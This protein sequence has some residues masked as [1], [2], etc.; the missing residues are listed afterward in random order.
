MFS[1]IA[2]MFQA[3]ISFISLKKQ[4]ISRY[5]CIIYNFYIY[6]KLILNV[7]TTPSYCVFRIIANKSDITNLIYILL[8]CYH[9][10]VCVNKR[11]LFY[12]INL[13]IRFFL[14]INSRISVCG[15]RT[16]AKRD[17][18]SSFSDDRCV[19]FS[20]TKTRNASAAR[21]CPRACSPTC[22]S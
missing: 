5:Y 8:L 6:I 16:S 14:L 10:N 2:I 1:D 19:A 17:I 3:K 12:I 11:N 20:K 4:C 7:L 22:Q 13:N 15:P 18:F 9:S 21:A